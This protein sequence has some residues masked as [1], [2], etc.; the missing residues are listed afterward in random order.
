MR[1]SFPAL[2]CALG[3]FTHPTSNLLSCMKTRIQL[4]RGKPLFSAK[5]GRRR[6]ILL[7]YHFA[8][9]EAAWGACR[10]F[11][12]RLNYAVDSAALMIVEKNF[13]AVHHRRCLRLPNVCPC[14]SASYVPN[15]LGG[16][17]L[18]PNHLTSV[19]QIILL[20]C[21]FL[22]QSMANRIF[23]LKGR[24]KMRS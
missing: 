24:L 15:P 4:I 23:G 6:L 18:S 11:R 9:R 1:S 2:P 8:G 22:Y 3:M 12:R 16:I 14:I 5:T 19:F 7:G 21:L 17:F 20:Q 10:H 13:G